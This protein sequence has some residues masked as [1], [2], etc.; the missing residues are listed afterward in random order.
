MD[1]I[2]TAINSLSS[3]ELTYLF[4]LGV[5]GGVCSS[6]L[7]FYLHRW[8]FPKVSKKDFDT[9]LEYTEEL[10]QK[11][12]IKHFKETVAEVLEEEMPKYISPISP[13]KDLNTFNLSQFNV[14]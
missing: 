5:I 9:L 3:R 7:A 10:E 11:L 2:S 13:D 1:F 4:N 8:L 12:N 14:E 6:T